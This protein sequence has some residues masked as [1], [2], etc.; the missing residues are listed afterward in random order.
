M[1]EIIS[2]ERD[3]FGFLPPIEL[4]LEIEMNRRERY[5]FMQRL[6]QD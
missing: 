2:K 1:V 4:R 6:N 5:N 3:L